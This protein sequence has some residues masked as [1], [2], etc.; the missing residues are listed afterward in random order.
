MGRLA[1]PRGPMEKTPLTS[2]FPLRPVGDGETLV[3]V[4]RTAAEQ[5]A[6][7]G[8]LDGDDAFPIERL[9]EHE[10]GERGPRAP[11]AALSR[12]HA[13]TGMPSLQ[14]RLY[15]ADGRPVR[16][17]RY[18]VHRCVG[19]GG[20]G[21]VYEATSAHGQ[22]VAL[23]TLR[24]MTAVG[25]ARFKNE[26]RSLCGVT[27]PNLVALYEL[28]AEDGEWFFTMEL[29]LGQSF[30][31]H[32]QSG[33]ER[34]L[35]GWEYLGETLDELE[36]GGGDGATDDG[37]S[38]G[39]SRVE[40]SGVARRPGFHEGRLRAALRQLAA[41]VAA[42]HDLGKLHRDLNHGNVLVTREGRVVVLDFGLIS[43]RVR[44]RGAPYDGASGTP[45]YMSPEQAAGKP[46]TP[47]SDWY[48]F[49]V[50]LFEALTGQLPFS[51]STLRMLTNKRHQE[52]P[53]PSALAAG[54][55]ADLDELCASLLRRAPERRPD[56]GAVLE[57]LGAAPAPR[58]RAPVPRGDACFTG[59][60]AELAALAEAQRAAGAAD[61]VAVVV[62][63]PAGMG[64]TCLTA[65]FL[66][67]LGG[68]ALVLRG[69]CLERETIP[70]RLLD[71][72]VDGLAVHLTALPAAE[73]RAL[74]PPETRDLARLFPVLEGI[75]A[76][77][78][79]KPVPGDAAGTEA[80][81]FACLRQILLRLSATRPVVLAIDDAHLGD[82]EGARQL[83]Q[84]LLPPQPG[85]RRGPVD[86][87]G[88][89]GGLLLVVTHETEDLERSAVLAELSRGLGDL[90]RV[91]L[92]PLLAEEACELARRLLA[93]DPAP[94][95]ASSP[96][97]GP[98]GGACRETAARAIAIASEG[99]P[100][101]VE[102][103]ARRFAEVGGEVS[104]DEAVAAR[105][106]GLPE[107]A[108]RL[109]EIVATAG[110]PIER[111][112]LFAVASAGPSGDAA[113]AWLTA[114]R[115][116][117]ADGVRDGD[118][119]RVHDERLRAIVR[120]RTPSAVAQQIHLDLGR[121]LAAR[122][123]ADPEEVAACFQRAGA[124]ELA[125]EHLAAAAE[126]AAAARDH[127]RAAALWERARAGTPPGTAASPRPLVRRAEALAMAGRSAAAARAYLDDLAGAPPAEA[128]DR[129]RRA[130]EHLLVA[131]HV[132]EGLAVLHPVLAA[133]EIR[134][135]A[136]PR[137]ALWA[138][139]ARF[140]EL[141]VR[142]SGLAALSSVPALGP[143]ARARARIEALWSAGKGLA[144][145]DP[146]RSSLFVVEALLGALAAGDVEHAALS[147]SWVGRV[148]VDAGPDDEAR[149]LALMDEAAR[150]ARR[151]GDPYL[152]GFSWF[153]SGLA[154]LSAGRFREAL[155]RVEESVALLE[156]R[157]KRLAWE[158]NAHRTV[159]SKALF[160][161]GALAE[162]GRRAQ[163]W[164]DEARARDD[165]AGEALASLALALAALAGGDAAGARRTTREARDRAGSGWFGLPHHAALWLEVSILLHEGDAHAAR[166]RLLALWPALRASQLLR[167]QLIR[168]EAL[169]LR[170]LTAVAAGRPDLRLADADAARLARERRPY[171]LAAAAILR[172]GAAHG[173][174]HI[175]RAAVALDEAARGYA[176]AEMMLHAAAAR[177]ARGTL[178]GGAEGRALVTAADAALAAEGVRD[179]A[180]WAAMYTGIA[181][182]GAW[183]SPPSSITYGSR[184][185]SG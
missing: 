113:L 178:L 165:R 70:H 82:R 140:V 53:P 156:T 135:P 23:K 78:D 105:L 19:S 87:G 90:R 71:A 167:I 132:A 46:A 145:I 75:D 137:L 160:Q 124:P 120:S 183:G 60:G 47:A 172:A 157:G 146:L 185:P 95:E 25:L 149:G 103:L 67:Q 2:D 162:R 40:E 55:P 109:L 92:G 45:A 159:C 154:R 184:R 170:G 141:R 130:A 121:A 136:T 65:R 144:T 142:G 123:G 74:L 158:G 27:H 42:L 10:G 56:A 76:I 138:L 13:E 161:L 127:D 180:R 59:R 17:G 81:A 111:G 96:A 134:W 32:V 125:A 36:P 126:R 122:P 131:G 63:G 101:A 177:R 108:L 8:E 174:G 143:E 153:C 182:A 100:L 85:E 116:L 22:R 175:G 37:G 58:P 15:E 29:V 155:A 1:S 18:D 62:L 152:L 11:G 107:P 148:L 14:R 20:M 52:A 93:P 38:A 84:L 112:V 98:V 86:V 7:D 34:P 128:L 5:S 91:T 9:D 173:R 151:S 77:A 89:G 73:A 147:L 61:P 57:V 181:E 3:Q 49:G 79:L 102:E 129:R 166:A 31:E 139:G 169:L 106:A 115:L 33:G 94:T 88:A 179:G 168:V 119:V 97:V 72:A 118:G 104:L 43:D 164:L 39:A 21:V 171:A 80:T 110:K 163:A 176:S 54:L 4:F 64:K 69:A 6:I 44:R 133:H 26:F 41:A 48:G 12:K 117:R 99:S 30:L 28:G 83:S 35:G 150:F 50:M 66:D 68:D 114:S 51:G 16:L 24:W